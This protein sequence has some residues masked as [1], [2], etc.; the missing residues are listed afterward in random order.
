MQHTEPV[1]PWRWA[2]AGLVLALAAR[3]AS[4]REQD[5][6]LGPEQTGQG[7]QGENLTGPP[8]EVF[9]ELA[10]LVRVGNVESRA[11]AIWRMPRLADHR[12]VEPIAQ[13]VSD[14]KPELRPFVAMGLGW[15]GKRAGALPG[16]RGGSK[17]A[18]QGTPLASP[19]AP[20]SQGRAGARGRGAAA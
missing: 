1:W 6:P 5:L 12:S 3:A 9:Q 8:D 18:G 20:A 10:Q 15:L 4:A 19:P 7:G 13:L 14:R 2:A 11:E 17:G 16:R